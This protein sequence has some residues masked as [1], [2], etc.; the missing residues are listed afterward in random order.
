MTPRLA[1]ISARGVNYKNMFKGSIQGKLISNGITIF[2]S[3]FL[4]LLVPLAAFA[5][6]SSITLGATS[7]TQLTI[8]GA[9]RTFTVTGSNAEEITV[10]EA[11]GSMTFNLATGGGSDVYITSANR[12][13]MSANIPFAFTCGASDSLLEVHRGS[14][15]AAVT[16]VITV[17]NSE[18]SA[19]N[20][21]GG[22]GSSG[23]GGGGGGS[24]GIAA[25]TPAPVPVPVPKAVVVAQPSPV[26][27]VVSPVFNK[28]LVRGQTNDDVKRLQEL[29]A[30]DKD[31]Y[32]EG[33]VSGF[34]GP[35]TERAVK[36]FQAKYG[37]LQVGRVGPATR[38]KL[39]EIFGKA[40]PS[41][42]AP[43]VTPVAPTVAEPSP[44]AQVVSPVFNSSLSKG[45]SNA[46][47]KR[48]QQLLNSD[49]DTQIADSGT[50]S[51]GNETERFGL[52]TEKA[53]QKFQEKYGLAKEGDPGYGSVG[54]KT[55][56]KL[57]ELFGGSKP[58]SNSVSDLDQGTALPESNDEAAK[59]EALQNQLNALQAQL[60]A[61]LKQGQ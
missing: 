59:K 4:S 36:R 15:Q 54:P 44:V 7:Q 3:L 37:L 42:S 38:A 8:N 26:A 5:A 30:G 33:V 34:F 32:P 9:T 48:L 14:A 57:N 19:S 13:I 47:V 27:Q 35:A 50:G 2:T 10:N 16:A 58:S 40:A 6:V 31:L 28:D 49:P 39:Q 21:S 12:L 25:L 17:S 53:V 61:M 18:C 1:N 43:V 23:S 51:P 24:G 20:N 56:A 41:T 46:D 29:L 52:L 55:R 60:E 45:M 11:N 22:G